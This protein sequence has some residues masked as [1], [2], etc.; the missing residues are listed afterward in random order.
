MVWVKAFLISF[1][2]PAREIEEPL[3]PSP[4][5]KGNSIKDE[6][7]RFFSA[8]KVFHKLEKWLN[9]LQEAKVAN[10]AM[11]KDKLEDEKRVALV[12]LQHKMSGNPSLLVKMESK[13]SVEFKTSKAL[14]EDLRTFFLY[15]GRLAFKKALE[16]AQAKYPA[17]PLDSTS[18]TRYNHDVTH[19]QITDLEAIFIELQIKE[20]VL[21]KVLVENEEEERTNLMVTL[22][23]HNVSWHLRNLDLYFL[24]QWSQ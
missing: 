18:F 10:E 8:Q 20:D 21:K 24:Q 12:E 16:E 7:H 23:G 1:L 13:H 2:S 11:L 5:P 17:H 6:H 3:S 14:K 4:P 22:V 9:A 15:R 19:E